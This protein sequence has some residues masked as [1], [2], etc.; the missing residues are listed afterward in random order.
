MVVA[1]DGA[2]PAPP[3]VCFHNALRV[4]Q[5]CI[6]RLT[7]KEPV[8]GKAD[9]DRDPDDDCGDGD[10]GDED[11]TDDGEVFDDEDNEGGG[12]LDD[13]CAGRIT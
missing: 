13:Y 9:G 7:D 6:R 3:F 5:H 1:M 10:E 12:A 4:S 11:I 2:S 8:D